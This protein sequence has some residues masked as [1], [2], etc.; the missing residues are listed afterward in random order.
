MWI[1]LEA[2]SIV[3]VIERMRSMMSAS[4]QQFESAGLIMSCL[5]L[6][7]LE[8]VSSAT[9]RTPATPRNEI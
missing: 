6:W 9:P 1:G 3:V 8:E 7:V 4:P 5:V 2:L